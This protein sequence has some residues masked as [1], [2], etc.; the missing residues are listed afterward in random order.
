MKTHF[1]VDE[2]MQTREPAVWK[3]EQCGLPVTI[4]Y[5]GR[6]AG[7]RLSAT[8]DL[9]SGQK[10]GRVFEVMVPFHGWERMG[11]GEREEDAVA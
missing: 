7:D 11:V 2:L 4:T 5:S 1:T 9:S 10:Y 8:W 3:G 6:D